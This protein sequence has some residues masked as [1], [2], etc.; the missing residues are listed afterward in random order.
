MA[1]RLITYCVLVAVSA[2]PWSRAAEIQRTEPITAE[3]EAVY[4]ALLRYIFRSHVTPKYRLVNRTE[5][6]L[7]SDSLASCV[8][9]SE[10][11]QPEP[12]RS[13]VHSLAGKFSGIKEIVLVGVDDPTGPRMG[14][15][16]SIPRLTVSNIIFN[17]AHTAAV[18]HY[19][20]HCGGLCGVGETLIL[21]K[22][23][24]QWKHLDHRDD[25][26]GDRD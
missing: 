3:H 6:L 21:R 19:Q 22:V 25:C 2:V 16:G 9:L 17:Q 4:T 12:Q 20:A 23:N 13:V 11:G 7:L 18:V 26:G 1:K 24:G 15:P 14:F 8:H 5:P 10:F